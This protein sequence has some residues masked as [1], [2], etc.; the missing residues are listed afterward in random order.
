M[1]RVSRLTSVRFFTVG[2]VILFGLG[3]FMPHVV[4]AKA[5]RDISASAREGD[6][7]DGFEFVGSGG[8]SLLLGGPLNQSDDF[9]GMAVRF[10]FDQQPGMYGNVAIVIEIDSRAADE[11]LFRGY[12][13]LL[14]VP[15]GGH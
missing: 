14:S 11:Q 1:K 9:G 10:Y 13:W 3:V 8:G 6:P 15:G 2:L 7:I 4:K 5:Y 12:S